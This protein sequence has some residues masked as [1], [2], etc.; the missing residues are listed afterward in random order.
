MSFEAYQE[1]LKYLTEKTDINFNFDDEREKILKS[2]EERK[3]M[4]LP[5]EITGD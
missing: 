2:Y 1:Y 3:E 5:T 4:L